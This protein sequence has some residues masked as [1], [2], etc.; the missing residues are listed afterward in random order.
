MRKI[1]KKIDRY[2]LNSY[3]WISKSFFG[4]TAL[5]ISSEIFLAVLIAFAVYISQTTVTSKLKIHNEN[6]NY[7]NLSIGIN[8]N[9]VESKFGLPFCRIPEEK[10]K[11]VNNYFFQQDSVLRTVNDS[12]GIVVAYF[13]TITNKNRIISLSPHY[14]NSNMLLGK[15]DFNSIGL[16]P[17]KIEAN[18]AAAGASW[19]YYSEWFYLGRPGGFNYYTYSFVDYGDEWGEN[20]IDLVCDSVFKYYDEK[21]IVEFDDVKH[22]RSEAYPNTFGVVADEYYDEIGIVSWNEDWE[23]VASIIY[24]RESMNE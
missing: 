24:K 19:N 12:D 7:S 15:S 13:I 9:Y 6:E 14:Q 10:E 17:E 20:T 3:N 22:L 5:K 4:K 21:G 8:Q 23:D 11:L 16:I 18:L 2:L 1:I